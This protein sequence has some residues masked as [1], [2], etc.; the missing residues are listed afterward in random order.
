[1]NTRTN[2]TPLRRTDVP[3]A[4]PQSLQ[5]SLG[6]RRWGY[7]LKFKMDVIR[8]VREQQ[9]TV[10]TAAHTFDVGYGTVRR[11]LDYYDLK[12]IPP[13]GGNEY[14]Q[15]PPQDTAPPVQ[16]ALPQ[17]ACGSGHPAARKDQI[18]D[19]IGLMKQAVDLL[20]IACQPKQAA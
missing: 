17:K 12:R 4:T 14:P 2:V 6:G 13:K 18:R 7:P 9:M 10:Q 19:A 20:H 16:T 8:A 3:D 15:A 1:M 11:W 5:P